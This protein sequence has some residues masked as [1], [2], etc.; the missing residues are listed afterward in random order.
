MTPVCYSG[1]PRFDCD[2][3]ENKLCLLTSIRCFIA[4]ATGIKACRTST[5][6]F[7]STSSVLLTVAALSSAQP[8]ACTMFSLRSIVAVSIAVSAALAAPTHTNVQRAIEGDLSHQLVGEPTALGRFKLLNSSI[9]NFIFDFVAARD[10]E[11]P[12]PDGSVVLANAGV[13]P[14]AVGNGVTMGVGESG[15]ARNPIIELD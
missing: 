11:T 10:E 6:S 13:Y 3:D 14:A 9:N 8:T 12:G 4:V 2:V 5:Y 15:I 1:K 7:P